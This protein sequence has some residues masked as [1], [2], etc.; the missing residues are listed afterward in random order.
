MSLDDN[1][2]YLIEA[3]LCQD[4]QLRFTPVQY[5]EPPAVLIDEV[6]AWSLQV[7]A[8]TPRRSTA[9]PSGS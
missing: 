1:R 2:G 7:R 9:T 4:G 5:W 3:F 6:D 8:S